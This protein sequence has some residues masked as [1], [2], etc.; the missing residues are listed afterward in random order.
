MAN[1]IELEE[2]FNNAIQQ[3]CQTDEDK[4]AAK[5]YFKDYL[6]NDMI[7]AALEE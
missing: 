6:V 3:H 2:K 4:E 5:K 7:D 1:Y